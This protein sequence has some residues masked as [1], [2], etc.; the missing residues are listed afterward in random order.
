MENRPGGP[1]KWSKAGRSEPKKSGGTGDS[2]ATSTIGEV[3]ASN[4]SA[5]ASTFAATIP[6]LPVAPF[7]RS[8]P[9]RAL[10]GLNE[11][12][13]ACD[14]IPEPPVRV[15]RR[16]LVALARDQLRPLEHARE[17]P[18]AFRFGPHAGGAC[19][20]GAIIPARR[21]VDAC[22]TMYRSNSASQAVRTAIASASRESRTA[23]DGL[24]PDRRRVTRRLPPR[25]LARPPRRG[26]LRS[27]RRASRG[28]T[29]VD[30]P[31]GRRLSPPRG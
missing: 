22:P 28:R 4:T 27:G 8:A 20:P 19:L 5:I 26:I 2:S 17:H 25:A 3:S 31:R 18:E 29:R 23:G 21:Q 1:K 7:R 9:P 30:G 12:A 14:T 24:D 15:A 16:R 13:V 11:F 10:D 6:R